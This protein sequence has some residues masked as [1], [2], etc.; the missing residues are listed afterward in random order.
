MRAAVE[1]PTEGAHLLSDAQRD[2]IDA[3]VAR[4]GDAVVKATERV[5]QVVHVEHPGEIAWAVDPAGRFGEWRA[6]GEQALTHGP[7]EA[8]SWQQTA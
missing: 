1:K 7:E 6:D 4:F 2:V 3:L 8:I 5:A